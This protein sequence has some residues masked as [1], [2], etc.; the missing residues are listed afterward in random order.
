MIA[1][2]RDHPPIIACL[3]VRDAVAAI[4]FYGLVF[5]AVEK[6][7]ITGRDNLVS[8]A[9]LI[10]NDGL[11]VL[12]DVQPDNPATAAPAPDAGAS[13]S[14]GLRLAEPRQVD[15]WFA[16]A[17]SNGATPE[18]APTNGFWGG[19]FAALRDPFGHRWLLNAPSADSKA[20]AD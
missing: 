10:I 4:R 1:I 3:T 14:L 15:V 19:R 12:A 11:I 16:R 7:R 6:R 13:V 2:G 18:M 5:E 9:E 8:H 20:R 17:I